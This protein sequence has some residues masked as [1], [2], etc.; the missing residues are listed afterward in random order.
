M[1]RL[2]IFLTT[3][4]L[5]LLLAHSLTPHDHSRSYEI[6][7]TEDASQ[8]NSL[9]DLFRTAFLY[10]NPGENHLEEYNHETQSEDESE[11][12]D[13]QFAIETS[14]VEVAVPY[15]HVASRFILVDLDV[16]NCLLLSNIKDRAPP[17]LAD[18]S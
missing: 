18:L 15:I 13:V 2:G 3:L 9:L 7:V 10:A 1:K 17:S 4:S 12:L 16:P 6:A 5:G 8:R 11:L 14:S